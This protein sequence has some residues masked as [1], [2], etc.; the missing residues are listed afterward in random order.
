MAEFFQNKFVIKIENGHPGW[1]DY[2]I[3]AT[4]EDMA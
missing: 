1:K 2:T 3:I 4:R